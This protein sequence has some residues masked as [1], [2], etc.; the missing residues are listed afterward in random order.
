MEE[1]IKVLKEFK[2]LSETMADMEIIKYH[3]EDDL[4]KRAEIR[5]KIKAY[6]KVSDILQIDINN[7]KIERINK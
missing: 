6:Y 1:I 5:E 2:D 7:C 3:E 4:L